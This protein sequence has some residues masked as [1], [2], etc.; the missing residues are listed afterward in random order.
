MEALNLS[1]DGARLYI[2]IARKF[3]GQMRAFYGINDRIEAGE[4][5]GYYVRQLQLPDGTIIRLESNNGFDTISITSP[6]GDEVELETPEFIEEPLAE[7]PDP[8]VLPV[9]DTDNFLAQWP[10]TETY[11]NLSGQSIFNVTL[12]SGDTITPQAISRLGSMMTFTPSSTVNYRLESAYE[13]V[14]LYAHEDFKPKFLAAVVGAAF[15]TGNVVSYVDVSTQPGPVADTMPAAGLPFAVGATE[16]VPNR[17]VP[18]A[19]QVTVGESVDNGDGTFTPVIT[20]DLPIGVD[21]RFIAG[22]AFFPGNVTDWLN[23]FGNRE[24]G[25]PP[26]TYTPIEYYVW[27]GSD[28]DLLGTASD[29][30]YADG[31]A[32][33]SFTI[34]P[35]FL[36]GSTITNGTTVLSFDAD[37]W[38]L[39]VTL[40][41]SASLP[42]QIET[43]IALDTLGSFMIPVTIP[44]LGV[45]VDNGIVAYAGPVVVD[46]IGGTPYDFAYTP[47]TSGGTLLTDT[48]FLS[49][50]TM[51]F[52]GASALPVPRIAQYLREYT[53][54]S[55]NWR[56]FVVT[57]VVNEPITLDH[58]YR[59]N[60]LGYSSYSWLGGM[61]QAQIV[62]HWPRAEGYGICV[63][64][65]PEDYEATLAGLD[66]GDRLAYQE[67]A[68]TVLLNNFASFA[69]MASIHH[70]GEFAVLPRVIA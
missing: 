50:S 12:G 17:A 52:N 64:E 21:D 40:V 48:S 15:G 42:P 37:D 58:R 26:P 3:L 23:A 43:P 36:G 20:S 14:R 59:S 60:P 9:A 4:I 51:Y 54:A 69:L 33:D 24:Y 19:L 68:I 13:W 22:P 10:Y 53:G 67:S 39:D 7:I 70:V 28:F 32:P 35:T 55:N 63:F 66:P 46:L 31:V 25:E 34:A 30:T 8:P 2:P 65:V 1:G 45:T 56:G 44:S 5:G 38:A 47:S 57:E 29:V 18:I 6:P 61:P 62:I 49:D 16:F 27:N 11:A 41:S